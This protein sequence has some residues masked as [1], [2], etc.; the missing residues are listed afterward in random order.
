M[1]IFKK[2]IFRLLIISYTS[3]LTNC[4]T[5]QGFYPSKEGWVITRKPIVGDIIVY[6]V[7]YKSTLEKPNP[8]CYDALMDSE[9]F[10]DGESIVFPTKE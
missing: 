9:V 8:R 4:G 3:L 1:N 2:Y 6:C 7:T 10:K 5:V